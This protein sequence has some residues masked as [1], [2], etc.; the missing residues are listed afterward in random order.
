[1][2]YVE[3]VWTGQVSV[4]TVVIEP[5][6]ETAP[7]DFVQLVLRLTDQEYLAARRDGLELLSLQ[8]YDSGAGWLRVVVRDPA[9]R[10]AGALWVTLD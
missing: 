7:V 9:T 8:S 1:M 10:A 6:D 4:A 2:D 5:G 3:G